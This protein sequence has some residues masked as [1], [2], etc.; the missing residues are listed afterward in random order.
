MKGLKSDNEKLTIE[1]VIPKS[2]LI[3]DEGEKEFD[4]IKQLEQLVLRASEYTYSF[5]SVQT[6]RAFG[7]DIYEG[8]ITLKEADEDQSNL[9]NGIINLKMDKNGPQNDKKKQEKEIVLT[10]LYNFFEAEEI[11][12]DGFDSRIFSIKAQGF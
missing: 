4:K 1:D 12:F 6:I 11:L 8:K 7:R 2:A 10:N 5:K 3:N 9:L